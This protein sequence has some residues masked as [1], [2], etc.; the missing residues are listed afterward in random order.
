MKD[1]LIPGRKILHKISFLQ[2]KEGGS[3]IRSSFFSEKEKILYKILLR[4]LLNRRRICGGLELL[5]LQG[6]QTGAML[7][8][9]PSLH[10]HIMGLSEELFWM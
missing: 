3:F 2:K 10:G 4:G 7:L 1:P 6:L 8:H 9:N 5:D